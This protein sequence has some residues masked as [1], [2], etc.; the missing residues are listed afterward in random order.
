VFKKKSNY[1]LISPIIT[2]LAHDHAVKDDKGHQK[3]NKEMNLASSK[4]VEIHEH[5]YGTA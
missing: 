4:N 2:I 3:Y 5:N 1:T